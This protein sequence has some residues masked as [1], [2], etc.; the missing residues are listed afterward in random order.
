MD[1][2]QTI[3]KAV[4]S[5]RADKNL[6]NKIKVDSTYSLLSS[7]FGYHFLAHFSLALIACFLS[8][9]LVHLAAESDVIP[10]LEALKLPIATL[11]YSDN[12]VVDSKGPAG[13][14][15]PVPVSDKCQAFLDLKVHFIQRE[16]V[17]I[18]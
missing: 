6:V 15:Y 5:E 9:S 4:R 17:Q 7:L 13:K 12:V 14:L 1:F 2:A 16:L 10:V 8:L 11:A 3:I 18:P